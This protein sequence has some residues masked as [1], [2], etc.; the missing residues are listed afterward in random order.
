MA[1]YNYNEDQLNKLNES[2][3][4]CVK[5]YSDCMDES[6]EFHETHFMQLKPEVYQKIKKLII[7]ENQE[8]K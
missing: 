7:E 4:I 5:F 2:H 6:R 8:E 1:K 3:R